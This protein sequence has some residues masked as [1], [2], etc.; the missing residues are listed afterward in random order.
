MTARPNDEQFEEREPYKM[1]T[2][3]R[4]TDFS[5]ILLR[6][7]ERRYKLL[8]PK[9]GP[10]G[11]R[12]YTED[13][14]NVLRRVRELIDSGRSIGEIAGMGR[15][16]VLHQ[17]ESPAVA[18]GEPQDG[19]AVLETPS[20]EAQTKIG[21]WRNRIV[22]AA[23]AMDER[24]LSNALDEGFA[25]V[26]ADTVIHDL[27]VPS[28]HEIGHLWMTGRC[29]VASEHLATGI[30]VH[31]MR[32]LIESA[33]GVSRDEPLR[34][35]GACFPEENHELG[36]LILSY[37]L[38]RRGLNVGFLGTALPFEDLERACE[39]MRPRAVLLSVTRP[40]VYLAQKPALLGFLEQQGGERLV[41]VGGAGVPEEDQD[42]ERT[43]AQLF[44]PSVE[45]TN[46]VSRIVAATRS[47]NRA[48][49]PASRS[50]RRPRVG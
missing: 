49:S 21:D 9:R 24:A 27:I 44:P 31:R 1:R 30:F 17:Q 15:E 33:T 39:V 13:D 42:V 19:R 47:P 12:L 14:L 45:L 28:A 10:G 3:A 25:S 29:T 22:Q 23:L 2:I 18:G 5:P 7:W 8:Q 20:P 11:H 41:C 32:K 37:H 26:S 35:V 6:A 16:A 36:L 50:S 4:L 48:R 43:G 40:A 38:A 46:A 34:V